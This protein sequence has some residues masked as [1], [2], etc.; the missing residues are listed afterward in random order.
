MTSIRKRYTSLLELRAQV[1]SAEL[2]AA[3]AKR[4]QLDETPRFDLKRQV[5]KLGADSLL[6]N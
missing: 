4:K 3:I 6:P 5:E 1:A 2:E